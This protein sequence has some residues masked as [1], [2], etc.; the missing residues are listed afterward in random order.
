VLCGLT[1]YLLLIG[2][3]AAISPRSRTTHPGRRDGRNPP[4]SGRR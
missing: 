3:R 1:L 4:T 2:I